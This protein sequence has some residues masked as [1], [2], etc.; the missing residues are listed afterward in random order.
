MKPYAVAAM[1]LLL[2][3]P[4]SAAQ[5]LDDAVLA[6]LNYVRANPARYADELRQGGS[7]TFA[8]EDPRALDDAIDFLERQAPLPP[9]RRDGRLAASAQ[10]HIRTQGPRGDVGHGG[11]ALGQRL[12]KQGLW[13]GLA[14]EN[15]SYGFSDPADVIRQ[16]VVDSGVATRGHRKNI[17]GQAFQ[18]AG[19]ACGAHRVYGEMCVIDFAGAV[20]AR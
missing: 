2:T 20:V 4:A 15:I 9:L 12:Q 6:E 5:G 17:F 14:A 1:A 10:A 3:Q 7:A 18:L 19:V 8:Y 11:V 13:A 16:L